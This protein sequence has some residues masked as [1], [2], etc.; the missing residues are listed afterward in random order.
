MERMMKGKKNKQHESLFNPEYNYNH[1]VVLVKKH[2]VR[3][4]VKQDEVSEFLRTGKDEDVRQT[5]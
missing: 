4:K 2:K 1:K 3:E 5:E